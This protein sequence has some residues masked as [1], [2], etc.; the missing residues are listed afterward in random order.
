MSESDEASAGE[1]KEKYIALEALLLKFRGQMSVIRDLT[2]E[3]MQ[4]LETQVLEAERN[5][6]EANQQVQW[7]EVRLKATNVESGDSEL[8]LFRRCQDLQAALQEKEELIT[9]LEHQLEEQKQSRNQDAKIVEEKAAKIKEWVMRKLNEFEVENTSLKETNQQQESQIL[10]LKRQI[11]VLE[12][13]VG[14]R[15]SDHTKPGQAQRLSSLTFGCFHVQGKSPQVR[16]GPMPVQRSTSDCGN[17]QDTETEAVCPSSGME[18]EQKKECDTAE[19][20]LAHSAEDETEPRESNFTCLEDTDIQQPISKIFSSHLAGSDNSA[21]HKANED[22]VDIEDGS[23]DEL[24]KRFR[25][26]RLNSSSSS[27]EANTPSPVLTPKRPTPSQDAHDTPASPKQ[28]RLRSP[29]AFNVALAKK[30]LS[31]PSV[32]SETVHGRTRNAISMLRPLKP[33]EQEMETSES[34]IPIEEPSKALA[35]EP[36]SP[37]AAAPLPGNKPPT[38]PLHRFPSWES[39]IYAVAK[40]GIRLSETSR[41]D[42]ANKDSSHPSSY[43]AFI[44]YTSLI[45]K[46][47]NTPVYTTV[48][49]RVALLS[50]TQ[51]SED[52]STSEEEE[53]SEECQ[54]NSG[55]EEIGLRASSSNCAKSQESS[56]RRAVSLSSMASESDYAIPPDAY[57]TDTEYSEPENKL[58]KTCS[59]SSD[60]GKSEPMEKSGYLLKM[61]KTWKKTW[62]RHWFVLKDGEL[63]YFKSPSDVIRKPQGQIELTASSTISRGDGK[64]ILQVVTGKHVYNLKADS[65]NLLEEWLMVLQCVH[66]IKAASPLFTQPSVRPAMKGHL[67]KMKHD[68]SKRVWC[69]LI[70]KTLYYF[71]CQEDKFPLGQIRLAGAHVEELN[72]DEDSKSGQFSQSTI[73]IQIVN[74]SP[75]YLHIDSP[76]EKAAWLYHLSVAAGINVGQVGTEFE[77][78][79]G[80]LHSVDGESGSQVWR[81]PMLC[82]SKEAL[83]TS[84]TTLPSQALQTEAIKLFKTCQLFINVVIDTPAIDYH[85]TLAQCA[86]QM[87]LTH[88]EL[89]NEIYCQLIKQTRRRQPHGQPGPLQGWQFLALCVGLFL[90]QQPILWLLQVHLKKHADPRTELGKYAIYCQRSM[91][92]TQQKGERQARPSRMEILSILLRNPYHHSLPFSVPVH[93]FNNTYQVVGFDASTTVEEFQNR[94]NQDMGMRKTGQS[95]FSLYSDDPTGQNLEHY[96]EGSLMICDIIAK[97]EQACKELHTGKSENSRTVKLTYKN[98]LYFSQQQRGE[99]ERERLLLAY[100]TN[101]EIAA[102]HFPVNK[103]LALEMSALLAQVEFGDF[104]RP[105]PIASGQAKSTQTLKQVLERFYPKHYR[106]NCSEEQLRQLSDR[107]SARWVSLKGRCNSECV[108]I[109]LTVARKWPFFGAKLFEAEPRSPSSLLSTHVWIAVHEDGLSVLDFTSMK[110]LVS[111]SHKNIVTF[112]GCHQDFM[113]VVTQSSGS[114]T[115]REKPTEKYL[116]TMST[117]KIRELTLLMASYIN[118]SHQQKSAAHH[119]SAPALLLAQCQSGEHH[120]SKSPPAGSGRPSKAP[121]LL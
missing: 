121:T 16:T 51:F 104:E 6:Y 86:L 56:L 76:H 45:Y 64:Q 114:N 92:R 82:F 101:E 117:F 8:K 102:G 48:K 30:H 5:A 103:E 19:D 40:S 89:Q 106:R 52:S 34:T 49:G 119:L 110:L 11:Q 88:S 65:P 112:G 116:F 66:K 94:L 60:S 99:T 41:T 32:V 100:Q 107:I 44:L 90:P 93:F 95:G 63:M 108:R 37:D 73:S 12:Q 62:K 83:S 20:I 15:G 80:R 2:T 71:R 111:F 70:G 43:P 85:V 9:S 28:P 27:S 46:N 10:E 105:F 113:L 91:E 57:S 87:C 26:Q 1:W 53:G 36:K 7:M 79:V 72:S 59:S 109:Y 38:P 29:N 21:E 115:A 4:Q 47:M 98:R 77:Q 39:R 13:A 14:H 58:Q 33:Q 24:N 75:T 118:S 78:L 61:V 31:Q 74:Q 50:N 22:M 55:E 120:R 81:H 54:S 68:Y 23:S 96:L 97:W 3:K 67:T 18:P 25:M 69:A 84:L 42:V 17:K 35:E